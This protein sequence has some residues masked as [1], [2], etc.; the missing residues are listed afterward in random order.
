MLF[1]LRKS[2]IDSS[3]PKLVSSMGHMKTWAL[4]K[5]AFQGMSALSQ[6]FELFLISF[7]NYH[8]T[9]NLHNFDCLHHLKVI[10]TQIYTAAL[11]YH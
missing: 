3:F 1:P 7:E 6:S 10:W 2:K 4:E 9:N 11:I 5:N 8:P